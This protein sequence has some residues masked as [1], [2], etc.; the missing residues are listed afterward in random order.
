[1]RRSERGQ[2]LS[3]LIPVLAILVF[4]V[5]SFVTTGT[6]DDVIGFVG[7]LIPEGIPA[8]FGGTIFWFGVGAIVIGLIVFGGATRDDDEDTPIANNFVSLF[9][10][11][12]VVLVAWLVLNFAWRN[13]DSVWDLVEFW[14]V[15][16]LLFIGYLTFI[17]TQNR[18]ERASPESALRQTRRDVKRNASDWGEI[19]A[20]VI[21]VGLTL[22]S[23]LLTGVFSASEGLSDVL[24]PIVPEISYG[25]L[26]FIGFGALGGDRLFAGFVPALSPLQWVAIA[27]TLGGIALILRDQ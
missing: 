6:A 10:S 14:W 5:M 21:V 19:I 4:I 3:T 22:F 11:L 25:V 24:L 8:A 2:S 12:G 18:R 1:V 16:P 26:S 27:I 7:P 15:L 23:G 9:R 13:V 20:G 17:Y